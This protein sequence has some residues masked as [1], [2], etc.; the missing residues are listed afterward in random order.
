MRNRDLEAGALERGVRQGG[1]VGPELT[2]ASGSLPA[3]IFAHA[4]GGGVLGRASGPREVLL[5]TA[6]DPV[7]RAPLRE[8][9]VHMGEFGARAVERIVDRPD[10]R[11]LRKE[12]F[13]DVRR[14]L[15]PLRGIEL[16]RQGDLVAL[17]HGRALPLIP[18]RHQKEVGA[19][20]CPGR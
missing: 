14:H 3:P 7:S 11:V 6:R 17:G 4:M 19:I 18:I 1:H 16:A 12:R 10:G 5:G 20:A 15:Q 2:Q 9:E 13:P 8:H